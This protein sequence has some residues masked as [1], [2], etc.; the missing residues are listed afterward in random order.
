MTTNNFKISSALKPTHFD[1]FA[2]Y[3][4]MSFILI[5]VDNLSLQIIRRLHGVCLLCDLDAMH[6]DLSFAIGHEVWVLYASYAN[7]TAAMQLA[8]MLQWIG[9]IKVFAIL[10]DPRLAQEVG[11][12]S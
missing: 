11:H 3:P 2:L 4:S 5:A 10:V 6:Y 1:E 8:R 12:G 7:Y 9:A